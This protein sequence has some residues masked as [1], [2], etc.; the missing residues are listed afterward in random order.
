MA[1]DELIVAGTAIEQ[2]VSAKAKQ[3]VI[4]GQPIDGIRHHT[5]IKRVGIGR[6]DNRIQQTHGETGTSRKPAGIGG[7][8]DDVEATRRRPL[9]RRPAEGPRGGVE[10]QPGR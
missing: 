7:R 10:A 1:S 8:H 9:R 5:A 6:A 2:V 4:S 3:L